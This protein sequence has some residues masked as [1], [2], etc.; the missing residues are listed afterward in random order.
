MSK[1]L[2]CDDC[3]AGVITHHVCGLVTRPIEDGLQAKLDEIAKIAECN[4]QLDKHL[5]IKSETDEAELFKLFGALGE[6][7]VRSKK[8][9]AIIKNDK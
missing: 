2:I 4:I 1:E 5:K 7:V 9:L 6:A 8:I 3:G